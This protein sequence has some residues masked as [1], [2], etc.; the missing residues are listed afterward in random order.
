MSENNNNRAA[1]KANEINAIEAKILNNRAGGV[2][3]ESVFDI[4]VEK[5][6][7]GIQ[8]GVL[9]NGTP[10]LTQT[11]LAK[12]CGVG[13]AT[14]YRIEQEFNANNPRGLRIKELLRE[15]GYS[16]N[17]L[18]IRIHQGDNFYNAY[19]DGNSSV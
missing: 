14:L 8:M 4:E 10:Y 17:S 5:E 13:R 9:K 12:L 7:N 2:Q 15:Q 16:E 1:V 11:G 3:Q 19:P 18:F 6:I